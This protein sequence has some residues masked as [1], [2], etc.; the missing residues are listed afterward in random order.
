MRRRRPIPVDRSATSPATSRSSSTP[1]ASTPSSAPANR[2]VGRTRSHAPRCFPTGCSQPRPSRASAP[3]PA[4]GIDWLAGMG[5]ENIEEFE[6][7][8]KGAEALT[9][10]SRA[11]GRPSPRRHAG[12]VVAAA[13]GGL[14]SDVDKSRAH[15][16]LRR[17]HGDEPPSCGLD[18]HRRAGATTTSRSSSRGGSTS[19]SIRTPVAVWQ[20]GEDRMVPMAHGAWLAGHIPGAESTPAPAGGAPV[21]C[22]QPFR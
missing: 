18:R 9:P 20:G 14:V 15:R 19:A 12:E 8:M 7:T 17:I 2:V 6:A 21:P 22:D 13:L 5:P 4:E 16:R 11:R 10:L 3:W 1:S